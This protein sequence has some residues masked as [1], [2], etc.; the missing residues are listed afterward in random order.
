MKFPKIT[1]L[2]AAA[3]LTITACSEDWT[4]HF[5]AP[6]PATSNLM[7]NIAA[8][9]ELSSF[10]ALLRSTGYD[11]VLAADQTYTVW[12]PT[13]A[14]LS[15]PDFAGGADAESQLR[16]VRNHI[17]RYSY[18]ASTDAEARVTMLNGKTFAF[19]AL[20][21]L[22]ASQQPLPSSNGLLHKLSS[23]IAYKYN[24]REYIDTH[25]EC[26]A[27]SQFVAAFDEPR[28]APELST[29][30]DSVFVNYNP[31]L[32]DLHYGVGDIANEDSLYTVVIADDAAWQDAYD[33]LAPAFKT[34]NAD[35]AVADSIQHVQ[36]SQ[37]IFRALTARTLDPAELAKHYAHE[38]ASNG[39]IYLAQGTIADIDT[40]LTAAVI[41]VEAEEMDSRVSLTGTNAYIRNVDMNSAVQG[42]G[43][44][45]YLEVS[46]GNVDGGVTFDIPGVLAQTYDVYVDFVSPIV[47]GEALRE[48]M[49]KVTF[50]L[51]YLNAQG[52]T[53]VSNNNTATQIDASMGDVISVKA[54]SALA[55]PVAD[56][57]DPLWLSDESHSTADITESTTLQVK[58]KVTATDARNGYERTFRVDRIRFVPVTPQSK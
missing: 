12:A 44:N 24:I 38:E 45:S 26:S 6:A 50:Q 40:C 2:S 1:L 21:P 9:G 47:D 32:N 31:L 15:S 57:Y 17:A 43:A 51:R 10:A 11:A 33:R 41:T 27:A 13:N 16:T 29:T 36:T 49:T 46:S 48:Q 25:A 23:T 39:H 3:L 53:A 5:E 18:P 30:Y 54:F 52:R 37:T 58:T 20:A 19:G 34:F 14:A 7:E 22:T 4:E 55:F 8:D 35:A 42:L 28:Y 56:Y